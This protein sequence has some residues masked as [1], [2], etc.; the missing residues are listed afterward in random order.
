MRIL[1]LPKAVFF[2]AILTSSIASA[3]VVLWVTDSY[4]NGNIGGRAGADAFCN[5]D[6]FKPAGY[7][8]TKAFISIAK[9]DEVFYMP[10]NYGV[11]TN[12]AITR[13]DGTVIVTEW[14]ALLNAL[15]QHLL[16]S[17][18]GDHWTYTGTNF[19]GFI[20]DACHNWTTASD[21]VLG[22]IGNSSYIHQGYIAGSTVNCKTHR[23]LYCLSYDS[24]AISATVDGGNGTVSCDP[25]PVSTGFSSTCTAVPDS[26]Y[27]VNGWT[28]DCS[29]AGTNL[30]CFLNNID[31]DKTSQVSFEPIPPTTYTVHA[32]VA[33]GS[34]S[35]SCNPTSVV[36]GGNSTCTAVPSGGYQVDS[37]T[38]DCATVGN[39][40]QCDLTNITSNQDSTVIFSQIPY[41]VSASVNGGNGSVSCNPSSVTSGGSS[42]CTAVPDSGYRVSGWTGDCASWGTNLECY[43][44]KIK[45]DKTSEVSF[46]PIPPTT[47]TVHATVVG[48]GGTVS[49]NPN[50]VASGG[51]STCTAVPDGGYRVSGWTGDCAFA[52]TN[53]QCY[54][55]KIKKNKESEVSFEPIPFNTYTVHASV[56][57]SG[58]SVSCDPTN[59]PSGGTSTC[60][61]VPEN[62]YRVSGWTGDCA[63]AGTNL[64]CYLSKIKDNKDSVVSFEQI[65]PN[66]YTVHATV[67]GG[68]GS[69]SCD[70]TSVTSGG[71]SICTAV[72]ESGYQVDSWTGDCAAAGTN[73]KCSLTNVTNN[74]ESTVRFSKP[75]GPDNRGQ[76]KPI[77]TLSFWGLSLLSLM[78]LA[79][80]SARSRKK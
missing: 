37:W 63:S 61:A 6:A 9:G 48:I 38:G 25:S 5:G 65:P 2:Y 26:G 57:G 36:S 69:V 7:T 53:P 67:T 13:P 3:D 29:S 21:G 32:T 30:Q 18:S 19:W 59:V 31:A 56:A 80:G 78:M 8:H 62:G 54:L 66:T 42:T 15:N 77:P 74:K 33:T 12:D 50:S 22:T 11:P 35:V 20:Q 39:N 45:E 64:Q 34:G 70:P 23:Q 17:V 75:D 72:P 40:T 46:E 52:G 71:S 16:N 41:Q 73:P 4:T 68:V 10:S 49:C 44:T 24:W 76:A 55:S 14:D 1:L 28:G 43:L 58:G 60:T 27:R 79:L 47:Y 51:T